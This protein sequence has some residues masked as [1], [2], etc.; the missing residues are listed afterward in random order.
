MKGER[1]LKDGKFLLD[2]MCG[3]RFKGKTL[4]KAERK[5]F[6]HRCQMKEKFANVS[7]EKVKR[8]FGKGKKKLRK[9]EHQMS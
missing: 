2:C 8:F 3:K 6:A 5:F 4:E 9:I 1:R 7:D